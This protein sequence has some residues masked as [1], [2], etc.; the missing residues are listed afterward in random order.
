MKQQMRLFLQTQ[1]GLVH[2][3]SIVYPIKNDKGEDDVF[4][5]KYISEMVPYPAALIVKDDGEFQSVLM[6]PLLANSM[7]TRLYF[8]KG[9]GLEHFELFSDK[10]SFNGNKILVWKVKF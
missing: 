2:P 1:Q 5:K 3:K 7:F 6:D 4:E 8:F 10:K 9:R